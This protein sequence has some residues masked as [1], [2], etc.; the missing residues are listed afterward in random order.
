M[1]LAM[2]WSAP[3]DIRTSMLSGPL[4]EHAIVRGVFKALSKILGL[5][6]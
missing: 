3:N 6:P 2:E 4:V 1:K 5:A